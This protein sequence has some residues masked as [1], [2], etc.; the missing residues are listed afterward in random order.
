MST[1]LVGDWAPSGNGIACRSVRSG[2]HLLLDALDL[3]AGDEV[4]VSAITH[5]DM[6]RVIEAHGLVAVPVDLD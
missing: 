1:R 4:L 2:F 3:A 5:P 6:V